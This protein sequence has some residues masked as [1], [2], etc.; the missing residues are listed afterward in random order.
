VPL[1]NTTLNELFSINATATLAGGEMPSLG[2]IAIGNGGHKLLMGSNNIPKTDV[3]QHRPTDAAL[4]NHMPFVLRDVTNDLQPAD[5][6][7]YGLRRIET[8]NGKPYVA[9]YLKRIDFTNTIPQLDYCVV[10][11][12]VTNS[13]AF[14]P[15]AGNLHPTP[16]AV[17]NTGVNITTGDYVSAT[18]KLPFSMSA[19]DVAEYLNVANIMYGDPGMAIISEIALCSGV[20]RV[21]PGDFNGVTI[22]YNEVVC[23]QVMSFVSSFFA[24]N[25]SNSG[26]NYL[27]DVGATEPLY[28]GY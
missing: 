20:D 11:N 17:S 5:R 26:I 18:A 25:F 14:A 24:M 23:A 1:A 7:M 21:L 15:N 2:Y 12:G 22:N 27:F 13:T 9:Y 6:A 16:P 10:D 8:Y 28:V 3:V 4:Y 19:D